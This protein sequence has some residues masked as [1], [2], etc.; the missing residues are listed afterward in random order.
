MEYI[1]NI[2]FDKI[3]KTNDHIVRKD[4]DYF[5]VIFFDEFMGYINCASVY[6][7]RYK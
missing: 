3:S 5:K 6:K 2:I 4:K 7:D 1:G